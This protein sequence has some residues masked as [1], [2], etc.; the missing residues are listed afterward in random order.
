M[1]YHLSL[2]FSQLLVLYLQTS[3]I[4][5]TIFDT[6]NWKWVYCHRFLS[7]YLDVD[8]LFTNIPQDETIDICSDSMCNDNEN[9]TKIPKEVFHNLVNAATKE[10]FF[11]FN[12]FY[13]QIDVVAMGS[14]LNPALANIFMSSLKINGSKIV[15]MFWGLSSIDSMLM[16]YL[17]CF[18][19]L[20]MEKSL[21]SIVFEIFPT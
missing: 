1:D 20:I 7:F 16:T 2:Q 10:S 17:Y 18:P 5:T 8:S 3:K 13:K 12:K 11:M 21:K 15:I 14:T 4:F 19:V 6:F 9:T